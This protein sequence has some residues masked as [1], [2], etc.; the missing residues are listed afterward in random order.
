ML[1]CNI[2]KELLEQAGKNAA[3]LMEKLKALSL[4]VSLAESCTAGFI[5]HLLAC[6]PGASSVLWGSFVCYAKEAKVSMLN[7]DNNTLDTYGLV[8]RETACAMANG[9]L[10]KSGANLAAAVT[11][12][13]GPDNDG[14]NTPVGTVWIAAVFQNKDAVAKEFHFSGSR[15]EIRIRAAAAVL[16]EIN[17][18]LE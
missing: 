12:L 11:G 16:E 1:E 18:F 8:S 17:R 14:S 10:Q 3:C 9:A 2:E 15:N 13:A 7:I 5:S 6:L 4:T